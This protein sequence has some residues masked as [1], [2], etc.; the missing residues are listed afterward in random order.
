M[1]CP[2]Y[3][4]FLVYYY[5]HS[6]ASIKIWTRKILKVSSQVTKNVIHVVYTF[7]YISNQVTKGLALEVV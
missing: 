1:V 2:L 6:P 3:I 4:D 7:F 5:P